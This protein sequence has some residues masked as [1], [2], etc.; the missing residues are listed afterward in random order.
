MTKEAPITNVSCSLQKQAEIAYAIGIENARI[1]FY[2]VPSGFF[3]EE[4]TTLWRKHNT[5]LFRSL[6]LY[7][8]NLKQLLAWE[9]VLPSVDSDAT[10]TLIMDYPHPVFKTICDIPITFKD[11]LLR[12]ATILSRVSVGDLE[13]ISSKH[14]DR[15]RNWTDAMKR[16]TAIDA[17]LSP[18]SELPAK[19]LYGSDTVKHF[20]SLHG[21]FVHDAHPTLLEGINDAQ[22]DSIGTTVYY[23]EGPY[24][25]SAE[26][27]VYCFTCPY[28]TRPIKLST[29]TLI[30]NIGH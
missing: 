14:K 16:A 29:S 7:V 13:Y 15:R 24:N 2:Q 30:A 12:A 5:A 28:S 6:Q 18:L 21:R 9:E 22:Q 26:I 19:D 27:K 4:H 1:P 11:Q 3:C 10:P 23:S 17:D 8:R 20:A 25:L